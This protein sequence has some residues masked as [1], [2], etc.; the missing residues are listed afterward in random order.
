MAMRPHEILTTARGI[1]LEPTYFDLE[2]C[3]V[4]ANVVVAEARTA[5]ANLIRLGA[6]SHDGCAYYPS[7]IA[8]HAPGLAGR[9]LVGEFAAA[10]E[11]AGLTLALY[12]N[13]KF[14]IGGA[15][16][17]HPEWAE[18]VGGK[19]GTW[20]GARALT[21]MCH[22]SPYF[23]RYLEILD[24]IVSRYSPAVM[25]IDCFRVPLGCECAWCAAQAR[26]A[27]GGD[28]PRQADWRDPAWRSYF[29]WNLGRNRARAADIVSTI[30]RAR[31][32]TSVVFNRGGYW[33][34]GA[35]S[36]EQLAA[37][38][39][40]I[41]DGIHTESAVRF[42]GEDFEHIDEQSMIA[43][44]IGFP[45]WVWVEYSVF[46]WSHLPC[47]PCELRI[48]ASRVLAHGAR[49]MLWCLP[50]APDADRSGL[51][52]VGDIY[53][54]AA[55]HVAC[56]EN[57]SN[58]ACAAV[59]LSSQTICEYGREA[60]MTPGPHDTTPSLDYSGEV[61]GVLA[62]LRRSHIPARFVLDADVADGRLGGVDL[63][64]LPNTACLS[65]RQCEQIAQF[66]AQGGTV[67]A[68]YE[69]S[70][71]DE[72]GRPRDNFGLADIFGVD[73][74]GSGPRLSERDGW[75][76]KMVASYVLV[77][78]SGCMPGQFEA[79]FR[80]PA[81]GCSVNVL[82]RPG[83]DVPGNLLAPTRYYCDYP[84]QCTDQPGI[85][86]NAFGKGQCVYVPWQLGLTYLDR[87]F[88]EYRRFVDG[89]ARLAAGKTLPVDSDL[90]VTV[91]LTCRRTQTGDL[92]LHLLNLT[93]DTRVGVEHVVP[94]DGRKLLIDETRFG[95]VTGARAL[96]ADLDLNVRQENGCAAVSLP[97]VREYE[98]VHLSAN[99]ADGK[100][101]LRS[102]K[103][104]IPR[105][106]RAT[107]SRVMSRATLSS[108]VTMVCLC[109]LTACD[110]AGV[111]GNAARLSAVQKASR[112]SSASPLIVRAA[113]SQVGKTTV[114]DPAYV[115]LEY[116]G[117]DVPIARGVCTDVVV[118]ALR[119]AFELDLQKL[120]HEDMNAAFSEYP[121]IW[122]LRKP[123]KNI[124]H[125]RVPNLRCYFERKG[126]SL[127]VSED[128]SDY[129]P[130]DLVTCT[131]PR[132]RPHIMVVSDRRAE[133][134][135]PLVIHNIGRG[136]Q[137]ENRL[138]SFPLTGHYRVKRGRS[139]GQTE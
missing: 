105:E 104:P 129:K 122:G 109:L 110:Q 25:Y 101:D 58:A 42:Y 54:L 127:P 5:G 112:E 4:D 92:V 44:A 82:P 29:E 90:P 47:P 3:R 121:K 13:S 49:P 50:S 6:L 18:R 15:F 68:T 120:V 30:R 87:G 23:D 46:P 56:F 45:V 35:T 1:A 48:K 85:V 77:E 128:N 12:T 32:D 98:V 126:W 55:E 79:G 106:F 69:A 24:E 62:A 17:E 111:A 96:V 132:N 84:G 26:E 134:G 80:F 118:R 78:D 114:Y 11:Q 81:G 57:T 108:L 51:P 22:E 66:V 74:D 19:V 40:E 65:T 38:A 97:V 28:P 88:A 135:T 10:C 119:D 95:R 139:G 2:R 131:V 61:R 93:T 70:L 67:L 83:S 27:F 31:P 33:S 100:R 7:A 138:F 60:D 21:P 116:P 41:A 107:R 133:D 37:F 137:E 113:R 34:A 14:V 123:D 115:G 130:G 9:D 59:L 39:H 91:T 125:R 53:R 124:D 86:V 64:V 16:D 43:D 94:V 73:Y 136:T 89:V 52:P 102:G 72:T 99:G 8:P 71:R 75:A 63:L 20:A 103:V 117:G 36:P 76:A